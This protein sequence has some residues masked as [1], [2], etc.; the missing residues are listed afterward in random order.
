MSTIEESIDVRV[1]VS[2]ASEQWTD[3]VPTPS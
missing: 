1:P 2:A 3:V